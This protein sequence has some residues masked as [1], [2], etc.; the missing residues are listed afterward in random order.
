MKK[1]LFALVFMFIGGMVFAIV[2]HQI[3]NNS[4]IET[5]P[6][7]SLKMQLLAI[8]IKKLNKPVTATS[9]ASGNA[10]FLIRIIK[11]KPKSQ[12]TVLH[13]LDELVYL[14]K[15][16]NGYIALAEGSYYDLYLAWFDREEHIVYYHSMFDSGISS[17]QIIYSSWSHVKSAIV[18]F[19]DNTRRKIRSVT[20]NIEHP[21]KIRFKRVHRSSSSEY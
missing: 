11:K 12:I 17:V 14:D 18:T 13:S 2:N 10:Y 21:K 20:V 8:N 7:Y 5:F 9:L 16:H 1:I 19:N 3:K 15:N 4:Y 6:K